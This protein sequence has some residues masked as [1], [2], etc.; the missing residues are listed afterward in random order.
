MDRIAVIGA[1][2]WGTALATV[3]RRA[4][5]EVVLWALEPE[6]AAAVNARHENELT[7]EMQQYVEQRLA[8]GEFNSALDVVGEGLRLLQERELAIQHWRKEIAL[9]TAEAERGELLDGEEVFLELERLS[10]PS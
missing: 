6:V 2:A 1:G 8:R 7:P 10:E 5:R 9:D 3:A 4:G